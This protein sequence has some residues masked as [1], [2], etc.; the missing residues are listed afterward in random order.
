MHGAPTQQHA[1]LHEH[2]G[3]MRVHDHPQPPVLCTAFLLPCKRASSLCLPGR[4]YWRV[5]VAAEGVAAIA[6][7]INLS[8]ALFMWTILPGFAAAAYCPTLV[9]ERPLINRSAR[10]SPTWSA[11]CCLVLRCGPCSGPVNVVAGH[12]G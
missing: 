5:G 7:S 1:S 10:C 11:C 9:E 3:S 4:L 2:R 12:C 8:A 6:R